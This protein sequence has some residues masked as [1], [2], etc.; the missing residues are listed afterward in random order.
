MHLPARPGQAPAIPTPG[1]PDPIDGLDMA[2]GLRRMEGDPELYIALLRD[3]AMTERAAADVIAEALATDDWPT[4]TRRA[5]TVK[6]LSGTFGAFRL[7]PIAQDL[8]M[9]LREARPRAEVEALL[10]R[11]RS[12]LQAL[13]RKSVV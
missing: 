1:L 3:F 9:G 5:H 4:A 13:D 2:I 8:E 11:F 7:Q 6:G 12:E 10:A